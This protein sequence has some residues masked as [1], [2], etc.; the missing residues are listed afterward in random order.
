MTLHAIRHGLSPLSERDFRFVWLGQTAS[1][2]GGAL[3]F[4]AL[5]WLVLDRSD[6]PIAVTVLFLALVVPRIGLLLIGGVVTDRHDPRTV[7]IWCD[8]VQVAIVTAMVGLMLAG[9]LP[10][11][12]LFGLVALQSAVGGIFTPAFQSIVPRLV[13]IDMR[14]T[15]NALAAL[16]P[17]LAIALGAPIRGCLDSPDRRNRRAH[18]QRS[19]LWNRRCL[20]LALVTVVAAGAGSGRTIFPR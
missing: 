13:P 6:S 18:A 9:A 7:M 16:T 11:P 2:L 5:I 20:Y 14:D 12:L 15:A 3:Q 4:V 1:S 10:L 8:A 17:Q 19:L